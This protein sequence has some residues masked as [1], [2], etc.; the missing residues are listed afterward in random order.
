ML[1]STLI[2]APVATDF[3]LALDTLWFFVASIAMPTASEAVRRWGAKRP[4]CRRR[5]GRLLLCG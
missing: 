5:T 3:T 2:V 4:P 1:E